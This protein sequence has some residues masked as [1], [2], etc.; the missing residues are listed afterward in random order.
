MPTDVFLSTGLDERDRVPLVALLRAYEAGLGVSLGFQD[1]EAEIA[2]LPGDYAP[3]E[4]ALILARSSDGSLVGTV[5]VRGL[6][7]AEG[8]CEMKRLYVAPAGRG[9]GLGR[10]LAERAIEEARRLGYRGMRLD[11]LPAMRE[12]QALYELLGFRDIANYN[13]NPIAGT[14]FLEKTL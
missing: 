3:P 8:I 13:G 12:A 5:A 2:S 4:G 6:D 7:G 9:Q 11:T 1:F 10:R 14:R